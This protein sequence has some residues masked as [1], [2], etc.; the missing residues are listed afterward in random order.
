MEENKKQRIAEDGPTLPG[1]RQVLRA[2]AALAVA[3]VLLPHSLAQAG[4]TAKGG[5]TLHPEHVSLGSRRKLGSLE[6][7]SV[8]LGV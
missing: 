2:G 4:Q 3:S 7:S 6:V 1:R 5:T 8:G